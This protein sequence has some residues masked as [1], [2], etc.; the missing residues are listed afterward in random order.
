MDELNNFFKLLDNKFNNAAKNSDYIT[1]SEICR[2]KK[3][4]LHLFDKK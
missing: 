4:L 1:M 2:I 3:D